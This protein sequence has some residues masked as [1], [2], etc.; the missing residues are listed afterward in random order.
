MVLTY[1]DLASSEGWI[2]PSSLNSFMARRNIRLVPSPELEC[3]ACESSASTFAIKL[4]SPLDIA[5]CKL[6]AT[7][8][9]S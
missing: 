1:R 3:N 6:D 8:S 9:R 4:S 2:P 7:A 5:C